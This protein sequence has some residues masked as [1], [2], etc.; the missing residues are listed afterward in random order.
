M[1]LCLVLMG[2][3]KSAVLDKFAFSGIFYDDSVEVRQGTEVLALAQLTYVAILNRP[4]KPG[5]NIFQQLQQSCREL[6]NLFT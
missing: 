1:G 4:R 3:I 5:K 2:V 6:S